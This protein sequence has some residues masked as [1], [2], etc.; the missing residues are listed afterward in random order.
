MAE[1]TTLK[2]LREN[3]RDVRKNLIIDAATAMFAQKPFKNVSMRDIAAEAGL[4][5]A[6]IYHYFS[7]RDE[8]FVEAFLR[9]ARRV[10]QGME[11]L[12]G[13]QGT[14]NLEQVSAEYLLRLMDDDSFFPMMIH[15]M[16]DGD[17]SPQFVEKFNTNAVGYVL[18]LLE[19]VFRRNGVQD[20]V[21]LLAHAFFACLNGILITFRNNPG[22]THQESEK[23]ILRLASLVSAVFRR[24]AGPA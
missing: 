16:L 3:E 12:I 14:V 21:R 2:K 18:D 20:N 13:E 17:I 7:D 8:L 10:Q 9:E 24:G 22:R 19:D 11:R 15:F 5:P 4:S 6:S 23:H 1:K